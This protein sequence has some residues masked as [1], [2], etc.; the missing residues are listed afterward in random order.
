MKYIDLNKN[1]FGRKKK[2]LLTKKR[3]FIFVALVVLFFVVRVSPFN[4]RSLLTP[5]SV[6][7]QIIN[8]QNLKQTDGRTNILVLG[9]DRRSN[10]GYVGGV[11]TD[12]IMVASIDSKKKDVVVI[13]IPR[14]LWVKMDNYTRGKINSCYAFGGVELAQKVVGEVLGI[15]LH[16]FVVVDFESFEKAIDILGGIGVNVERAFDDYK[17]PKPG[18]ENA[19]PEDLRW[20]HVHFDAGWQQM[21]GKTALTFARSRHAEGPEGG[22]FA[23]V[24]RQQKVVLAAK[25]KALSLKTLANP[26]K[27][28]E[29]YALFSDSLETNVGLREVERFYQL[30]RN[31]GDGQIRFQ[32]I[33]G[34]WDS[35]EALLYTPE[36]ELYGGA[37]VLLPKAGNFSEIYYFVQKLLFGA[38]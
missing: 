7:S 1:K 6:F 11:L 12:T 3:L 34:S 13:S 35:K 19:E 28:Q 21:D 18:F 14:D 22:D 4:I 31:F 32:L 17:F 37:F 5:V 33:D 24:K 25:D 2:K 10:V 8:P 30:S 20:E 27:L 23:R 36:V 16:Y 15:P 38:Q 29:L 26:G 9:V